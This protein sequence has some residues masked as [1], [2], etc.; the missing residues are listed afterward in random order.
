M[1]FIL[2]FTLFIS[3]YSVA[4]SSDAYSSV[5]TGWGVADLATFL[6]Y[7]SGCVN[8]L[9]VALQHKY[10][11]D[12]ESNIK[13]ALTHLHQQYTDAVVSCAKAFYDSLFLQE[14]TTLSYQP[15]PSFKKNDLFKNDKF[16]PDLER[17]IKKH[18][19]KSPVWNPRLNELQD[20]YHRLRVYRN[21][22]REVTHIEIP[23]YIESKSNHQLTHRHISKRDASALNPTSRTLAFT[24]DAQ[25][26]AHNGATFIFARI[27][28]HPM[29][30]S[31][32][33]KRLSFTAYETQSQP[34][35]PLKA[36]P[37]DIGFCKLVAQE[38]EAL[39]KHSKTTSRIYR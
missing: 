19:T 29:S 5:W 17:L 20:Y 31:L 2:I 16:H 9:S 6:K 4:A 11:S 39:A 1:K 14:K 18:S 8:S 32:R 22:L 27:A 3:G 34:E 7:N 23:L 10:N 37:E 33:F 38:C 36:S 13:E 25:L 30:F 12:H 21:T 24:K 15:L 28:V 35:S 26:T